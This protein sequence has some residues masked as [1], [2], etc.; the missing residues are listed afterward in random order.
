MNAGS[1]FGFHIASRTIPLYLHPAFGKFMEFHSSHIP[2][3]LR[4]VLTEK[5]SLTEINV[6]VRQTHYLAIVRLKQLIS[7]GKLHLQSFP[8]TLESTAIDC[9][10]EL[11]ERDSDG[12]FI[13]LEHFF[14]VERDLKL[15]MDDDIIAHYRSLVFTKLHD[16]IFRL[17]RE[18]DPVLS[19]IIRNVK[20]SIELHPK[21][22]IK[23]ILGISVLK[24]ISNDDRTHFPELSVEAVEVHFAE[25]VHNGNHIKEFIVSFEKLMSESTDAGDTFSL[26]DFCVC[27][28]RHFMRHQVPLNIVLTTDSILFNNDANTLIENTL[29]EIRQNLYDRYVV[30]QRLDEQYFT[31]YMNAIDHMVRD[32]FLQSD[33]SEKNYGEY[34]RQYLPSISYEEYREHHRKQ[35]EYMAKL[36]KKAVR[37]RMKE[38]L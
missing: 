9:I 26:I 19:K 30:R 33:G 29:H 7:S 28:K 37:E 6:L 15:L 31:A 4:K 11:F 21:F 5:A 13:E 14:C 36:T 16:G 38:L 1:L 23:H 35:F 12:V 24:Y 22:T 32:T 34:L 8:I 27:I 18:N 25:N 10:A 20:S 17:Y 2:P 3:L